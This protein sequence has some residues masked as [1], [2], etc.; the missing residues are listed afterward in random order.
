M[1]CPWSAAPPH[2]LAPCASTGT[3]SKVS[4]SSALGAEE[5]IGVMGVTSGIDGAAAASESLDRMAA[6]PIESL[7]YAGVLDGIVSSVT[8]VA[9]P[10]AA[11][12][13]LLSMLS[14][15][16]PTLLFIL[17]SLPVS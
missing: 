5:P 13:S 8:G 15:G 14:A 3:A 4:A 2:S 16:A 9:S 1:L 12:L 6:P 17:I 10:D 11:A 7:L